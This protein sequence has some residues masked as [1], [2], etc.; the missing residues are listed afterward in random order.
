[1]IPTEDNY[2]DWVME[3]IGQYFKDRGYS[4]LTFSVGQVKEKDFPVDRVLAV[5][6]KLVGLQFKRPSTETWPWKHET[7]PHQHSDILESKWV[8]YCLPCFTDLSMQKIALYHSRFVRGSE[9]PIENLENA[10]Y[11]NWGALAE[12]IIGCWHGLEL[13]DS[14]KFPDLVRDILANPRNLY[15]SLNRQARE[16]YLIY[17]SER[18]QRSVKGLKGSSS[19]KKIRGKGEAEEQTMKTYRSLGI[20]NSV[21]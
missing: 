17:R 6:N 7:L 20:S 12:G 11:V 10:R 19:K 21:I 14:I 16:A 9:A 8:Y 2:V 13:S 5:G 18:D 15:L 3:G 1:V 4:V